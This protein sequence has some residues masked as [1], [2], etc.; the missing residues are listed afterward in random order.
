MA[1]WLCSFFYKKLETDAGRRSA[2][3]R[4]KKPA[5]QTGKPGG[6]LLVI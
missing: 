4:T 1:N 5:A 6:W 3:A 2:R